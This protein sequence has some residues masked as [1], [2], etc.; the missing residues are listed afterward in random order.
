M[1]TKNIKGHQHGII[2]TKVMV[3]LMKGWILPVGG[4]TSAKGLRAAYVASFFL[5]L[6][7][8]SFVRV[9]GEI[10]LW[11]PGFHQYATLP[12]GCSFPFYAQG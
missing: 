2:V 8:L 12:R 1:Q 3:T 10:N 6:Q 4:V 5:L 11:D 9:V 7:K